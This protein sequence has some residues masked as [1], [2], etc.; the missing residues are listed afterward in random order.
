MVV[1]FLTAPCNT[2]SREATSIGLRGGLSRH[3]VAAASVPRRTVPPDS[4]RACGDPVCVPVPPAPALGV[5][6]TPKGLLLSRPVRRLTVRP[7]RHESS[8]V[9]HR[10]HKGDS[11]EHAH[12]TQAMINT[13][14]APVR[15]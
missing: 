7:A 3:Y 5:I 11:S 13:I 12:T 1:P 9:F 8:P 2:T 4:I 14:P 10:R 15:S 6:E